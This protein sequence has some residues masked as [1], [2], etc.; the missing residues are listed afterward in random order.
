MKIAVVGSLNMDLTVTA[1]R[2]PGKGETILGDELHYSPGGKGANQ[3]FAIGRLGGDAAIFGCVGNDSFGS[4]LI[5]NLAA[6]G[7]DSDSV[8]CL[9]DIQTGVALITVGESDNTIVVV[10][11]AN[12]RVDRAYIDSVKDKLLTAKL[13]MMQLEIPLDTVEYVAEL[14][15]KAEIDV[16]LNPAPA[17]RLSDELLSQLRFITPN[18]HETKII[19]SEQSDL[20]LLLRQHPEKLIVTLGPEGTAIADKTGKIIRT[21]AGEAVVVDTT[22]AGDTFNGAF[23]FAITE[24]YSLEQALLFANTAAG[25]STEK[26][27]AQSGMPTLEQV[28]SRGNTNVT[29]KT[30]TI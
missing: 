16:L 4:Q 7:V 11:G 26:L 6:A 22:G 28:L 5:S 20:D 9:D 14:C 19:Y 30:D 18:E 25:M 27:G 3:A 13:V 12:N 2:I 29:A 1:P 24:G 15:S 21:A 17:V 10:P 23:A 8:R